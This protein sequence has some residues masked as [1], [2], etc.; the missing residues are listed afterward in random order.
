MRNS[1][2]LSLYNQYDVYGL[3]WPFIF[4]ICVYT[5]TDML[6]K[7]KRDHENVLLIALDLLKTTNV[8]LENCNDM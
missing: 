4:N 7:S 3:I 2:T 8:L 6:Y 1:V 5:E